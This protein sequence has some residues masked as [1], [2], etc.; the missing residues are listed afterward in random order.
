M[1]RAPGLGPP[2]LV[3]WPACANERIYRSPFPVWIYLYVRSKP[4][5]VGQVAEGKTAHITTTPD[6][7]GWYYWLV[8][9]RPR[10]NQS[11]KSTLHFCGVR[12]VRVSY[13]GIVRTATEAM[14]QQWVAGAAA[15]GRLHQ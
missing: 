11:K 3:G 4:G 1:G 2:S 12:P 13:F 9:G 6:Q 10:V 8:Y 14:R 7:P 5:N 15:L